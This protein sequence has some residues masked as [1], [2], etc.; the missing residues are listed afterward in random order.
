[1]PQR[2]NMYNRLINTVYIFAIIFLINLSYLILTII[3]V[4]IIHVE[5]QL[6]GYMSVILIFFII[7]SAGIIFVVYKTRIREIYDLSAPDMIQLILN[8]DLIDTIVKISVFLLGFIV[9]A[10]TVSAAPFFLGRLIFHLFDL[11]IELEVWQA[12]F[13]PMACVGMF[14]ASGVMKFLVVLK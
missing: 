14:S 1:M 2:I 7:M 9:W 12:A 11:T 13:I 4:K 5:K 3:T 8:V 10:G 6:F